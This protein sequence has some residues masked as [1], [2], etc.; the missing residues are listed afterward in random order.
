M[1][2]VG[3]PRRR[4]WTAFAWTLIGVLVLLLYVPLVPPVVLSFLQ[5][6]PGGTSVT[7]EAYAGLWA[8]PTL[9]SALRTSVLVAVLTA[10]L[11][12]PLALLG[13]M[14]VRQFRRRRTILIAM[15]LPLFI[16]AVSIGLAVAIFFRVL[17]LE[18]SL[19]T[20]VIVH[21]L[22]ALP[23]AFLII[24][25]AMATFDPVFLEAAYMQGAHPLRAFF[26]VELP[27][28]RPGILGAA[29][30]SAVLSLNETIRTS[31]VQGA[32]NSLQTYIW[33]TYRQVGVSERL[34]ALMSLLILA[35][36]F[37]V[38]VLVVMERRLVR[39]SAA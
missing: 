10:I 6:G 16:P 35:T 27:L 19:M 13:A 37:I 34:Y 30:F 23:F 28:I 7:L 38:V 11:T 3:A 21:I 20:I 4:L 12:A 25:A 5:S 1:E 39:R 26:D 2:V 33:A 29:M 15:I 17:G 31:L 24:L 22:W 32:R 18:P 8:Q 14:A 36:L 9:A